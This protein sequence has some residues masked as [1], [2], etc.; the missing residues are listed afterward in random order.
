MVNRKCEKL[1]PALVCKRAGDVRQPFG[2]VQKI[3]NFRN[4]S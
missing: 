2:F 1:R 4:L 3:M